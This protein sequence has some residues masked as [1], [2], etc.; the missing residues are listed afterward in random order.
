[1]SVVCDK[2]A[3]PTSEQM[4]ELIRESQMRSREYGICS[5]ER[6]TAQVKLSP[7]GLKERIHSNN[8]L[9]D[10]VVSHIK[11]FYLLLSPEDFMIALV[12]RDGYI[13]HLDGSE[14]IQAIF[15][16]RNCAPGYRWQE[17]DVGTSA[18][19]LCLRLQAPF[20][21]NDTD[22]YCRRGHGF[23][24][25]AAPIFGHDKALEGVL[26]IS[27]STSLTHPHTLSMI[28]SAAR[29]IE[30]QMR[31]LRRNQELSVY[32]GFLDN[33]L[34]AAGTGL[35]TFDKEFRIWKVNRKG[36]E[37]LGQEKLAG[38]QLSAATGLQLDLDDIARN[39]G[40]WKGRECYF[41][42]NGRGI[43]FFY[44]AQPVFS[45]Q[46]ALLGAVLVFEEFG[47]IK[48]LAN[49]ISGDRAFF[50][51]EHLIG[52]SEKFR[53]AVDMARRAS[54][55]SSTVLL[56]GETGTGKEL[57]AQA[58][59][60]ASKRCQQPFIPINCGAI[61]NEL[62]ESELFGYVDGAFT[63]ALKGGR[64]GKFEL[65]NGGTVLLDEIGDMPHDMQVKLL[66]VLQT[67]EVQP[68]GSGSLLRINVRIIASTHVNLA[69]AV[70]Q[71]R[72]RRDLFYRLNILPINIP[73]L[74]ERGAGDIELL[75]AYFI[76]RNRPGCS[77]SREV[78]D[79][80]HGYSWPGNVRELEN[81]I[82]RALHLCE[83]DQLLP[84]HLDLPVD[85]A[86]HIAPVSG[87]LQEIERTA[88]VSTLGK[89][90]WNMVQS[91]KQLG[92]SRATLYR[93]V[94]EYKLVKN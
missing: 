14:R 16:E 45:R 58:V 1:M 37:I 26:V 49:K 24:S 19:S 82:Q 51:F 86:R 42:H 11:E 59:H 13:L 67:G 84:E 75:A 61:P 34:E 43:H 27:G 85:T 25:S 56:L 79:E 5:E 71:N 83:D 78:L 30:E 18:I 7:E 31:L 91:A 48:K 63:G 65:A 52:Q 77:L 23:T 17:K 22:H 33:V 3:I 41:K 92:I 70:A 55:S 74:R 54:G 50:T 8:T 20:Q 81:T 40:E 66:R 60:N 88:I 21:L 12:D 2:G 32:T 15:A 90:D 39:P 94:K 57:F 38:K 62:L 36:E 87:T 73:P 69:E 72:F 35:L 68:V 93:K 28:T 29:S 80:L 64:P 46:N 89:T 6:N 76:E 9:Y 10:V 53:D 44:S 47:N 4:V